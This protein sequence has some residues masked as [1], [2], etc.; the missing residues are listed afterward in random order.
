MNIAEEAS[1]VFIFLEPT[2]SPFCISVE[3]FRHSPSSQLFLLFEYPQQTDFGLIKKIANNQGV[4]ATKLEWPQ[5][6]SG[7]SNV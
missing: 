7:Q 6:L 4:L 2:Y 5:N 1:Y 3:V